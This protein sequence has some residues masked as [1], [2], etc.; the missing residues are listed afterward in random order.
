MDRKKAV[1]EAIASLKMEGF[2][3]TEE[4]L[5]LFDRYAK[6]EISSDDIR[7]NTYEKIARWKIESP[8]SFAKE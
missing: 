3:F 5:A 7:K 8:E 6:G 2:V 4:E 1:E